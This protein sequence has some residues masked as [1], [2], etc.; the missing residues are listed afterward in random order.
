MET[1]IFTTTHTQS[2]MCCSAHVPPTSHTHSYLRRCH[3]DMRVVDV[4]FPVSS[5][6]SKDTLVLYVTGAVGDV[7]YGVGAYYTLEGERGGEGERERGIEREGEREREGGREY[8]EKR[9]KE[10]YS[11]THKP[12]HCMMYLCTNITHN[13]FTFPSLSHTHTHTHTALTNLCL[14]VCKLNSFPRNG[15]NNFWNSFHRRHCMLERQR[16][17]KREKE[18]ERERDKWLISSK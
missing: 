7:S 16:L 6:V 2:C 15:E 9:K 1:I 8:G 17:I 11:H 18:R 5:D 3:E 4:S 12:T 10:K 13:I 14:S